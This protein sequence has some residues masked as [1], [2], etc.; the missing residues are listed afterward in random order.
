[1]S[2][3]PRACKEEVETSIGTADQGIVNN[4][5][6]YLWDNFVKRVYMIISRIILKPSRHVILVRKEQQV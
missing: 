2:K 4:M 6:L 5:M 3:D 1:M